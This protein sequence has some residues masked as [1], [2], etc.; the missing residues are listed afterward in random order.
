MPP[1]LRVLVVVGFLYL[2]LFG[3]SLL[4]NGINALGGDTQERIFERVGNPLAGLFVGILGT[5]VVQSSSVST[6]TIVGLVASGVVGV[7]DAVPM[8]MGANIGTTVTNTLASIGH[9][10]RSAEFERAFAAATMHDFFN[11]IS[12]AVLLPVEIITGFVGDSAQWLSDRLVGGG[13][14]TFKSPIK[15]AVKGPAG[16]L[17]D[18]LV[19]SGLDGL[20][21]GIVLLVIGL[22][23]IFI[24]LAA[25]TRNMKSLV[26]DRVEAAINRVLA[27]GSGIVA[28]LIGVVMT[29]SVQ[30][31]S[32]TTSILI[33]LCASGILTLPNA[34]PVTLG[35]NIGTTITALLASLATGRPEALT[36]ALSHLLFN[37]YG[38]GLL[39]PYRPLRH[40]PVRLAER[41]AALVITRRM[42]AAGY[43][44][45]AFIVVPLG[46]ILVLG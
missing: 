16:W 8:V 5:V 36:V 42:L 40:L 23:A 13:G 12:V 39:Y 6:S 44:V 29:I 46:G 37:I 15:E 19:D 24:A 3:V 11:I 18:R 1:V 20:G 26:A 10:R 4:E 2:F 7:D 28:M 45:G 34:Y 9:V 32:I 33:P 31:S 22:A 21:L 38:I 30:S 43:V 17:E 35:A 41:L 27:Q 25:V 14:V